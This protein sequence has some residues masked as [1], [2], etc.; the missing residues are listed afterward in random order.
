MRAWVLH[1]R[2]VVRTTSLRIPLQY[3]G[4]HPPGTAR[5][6]LRMGK[7][8]EVSS[9]A[10]AAAYSSDATR[11]ASLR[12]HEQALKVR[13]S[14]ADPASPQPGTSPNLAA[15]SGGNWVTR[16]LYAC[17]ASLTKTAP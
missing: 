6:Q 3:T 9:R 7:T 4:Q 10:F 5:I 2:H 13:V 14:S 12:P 15:N 8:Q 11:S 16:F 1:W 17:P